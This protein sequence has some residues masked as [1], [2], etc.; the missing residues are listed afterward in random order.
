MATVEENQLPPVEVGLVLGPAAD[1]NAQHHFAKHVQ[2]TRWLGVIN[3]IKD[4]INIY[5]WSWGSTLGAMGV[6][7]FFPGNLKHDTPP[8]GYRQG[9]I[10]YLA[11][12]ATHAFTHALLEAKA[13]DHKRGYEEWKEVAAV[14]RRA[15]LEPG[16]KLNTFWESAQRFPG[17]MNAKTLSQ[18]D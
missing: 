4:T 16:F 17:P 8:Y 14:Q 5:N 2:A 15:D 13:K 11:V 10:A 12:C 6:F 18:K 3:P 7:M 1:K 9:F